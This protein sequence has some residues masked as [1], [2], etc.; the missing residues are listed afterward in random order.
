M[1]NTNCKENMLLVMITGI[2]CC[3]AAQA[4][5]IEIGA[6]SAAPPVAPDKI[7]PPT[8]SFYASFDNGL[9]AEFSRSEGGA[10]GLT[11]STVS[12]GVSNGAV[13]I[14][15]IGG[16]LNFRGDHNVNTENGTVTFY[17]KGP[18]MAGAQ[19]DA[20][21]WQVRTTQN[22]YIGVKRTSSG[23]SLGLT[24]YTYPRYTDLS[25]VDWTQG[26]F[27]AD[28]WYRITASWDAQ[29]QKGWLS[30][31][32]QQVEGT[33]EMPVH[34]GAA[35]VF[36]VGGS[37]AG[38]QVSG[39]LLEQGNSFDE[40]AIY[41]RSLRNLDDDNGL[42]GDDAAFIRRVET[43]V[44]NS[45]RTL[46]GLQN[47]G[48]WQRV[49]TWPAKLGAT[50][51]G[52]D[53]VTPHDE[54]SLDKMEGTSRIAGHFLY[55]YEVLRDPVY[56]EVAIKTG[57]ML[58]AAQHPAGYWYNNYRVTITGPE[59]LPGASVLLQDGVQSDQLGFLMA[60]AKVTGDVRYKNAAIE[61][62]EF[63]IDYQNPDG[64]WSHHVDLNRGIGVTARGEP[65]GGEINDY[66]INY[67]MDTMISLWHFSQEARFM[68][69][70]KRAGD[71]MV[72]ALI[73]NDNVC[74]W[75]L[76]YNNQ[77]QPVWARK[78]EP[79][80]LS[81][82]AIPVAAKALIE[83]Y[84]LSGDDR[85]LEPIRKTSAWLKQT[86][87]GGQMHYYYDIATGRPV[88][89]WENQIYFLDDPE[90]L[91]LAKSF[92]M[93]TIITDLHVCPDL[94][95][96]LAKADSAG[97]DNSSSITTGS[98]KTLAID[99]LD[100]QNEEGVW[101]QENIGG[102]TYTLG[103]G[104]PGYRTRLTRYMLY[105]ERIDPRIP[106]EYRLLG[107]DGDLLRMAS[108]ASWYAVDWPAD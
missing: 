53:R 62:G 73:E 21:L 13:S 97:A 49:Y 84:R 85:Y 61:C 34:P 6:Q 43:G 25:S 69:S 88:A 100:K 86:F 80:A 106:Q 103:L 31:D 51:Q 45:L 93:S 16:H 89:A 27:N 30:V 95:G 92:P 50:S 81:F 58:L 91:A 12:G 76:Q 10:G 1:K 32:G 11:V 8:L 104:F 65:Q 9:D 102:G 71:W 39:G 20:W 87:P 41:D 59:P 15:K 52:R 105:I 2:L 99:S 82:D 42:S 60:L 72:A 101:L 78:F 83:A 108:P 17:C 77:K 56:L 33:F 57:E 14:T 54:I 79:P 35:L 74:G 68:E 98:L 29:L 23:L 40:L 18:A 70:V 67:A 48:G 46:A 44:R 24:R 96:M 3:S 75:A 64:S 37:A 94:D 4:L 63:Y 19:G 28:T 90:Q 47:L 22:Y 36:Y 7:F 5:G 66:A 38:R 55:A 107:G 26:S